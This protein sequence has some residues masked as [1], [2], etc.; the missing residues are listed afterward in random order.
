MGIFHFRNLNEL[1]WLPTFFIAFIMGNAALN[2]FIL[3]AIIYL[4]FNY[5]KITLP[6]N[7]SI[8][9]L[10]LFFCYVF[11]I[12]FFYDEV[13]LKNISQLRFFFL[14]YFF[15]FLRKN[16]QK[17]D[18]N[19]VLISNIFLILISIDIIIQEKFLIDLFGFKLANGIPTGPFENEVAG[20]FISKI[21]FCSGA[22]IFLKT[23]QLNKKR[24]LIILLSFIAITL[25]T[26]RMSF[27]HSSIVLLSLI[28]FE[29]FI[30]KN[31]KKTIMIFF[32]SILM[33]FYLFFFNESF[34][35]NFIGKT[36]NQIGLY[37]TSYRIID[38]TKVV[39]LVIIPDD[40]NR[41]FL[42]RE[43][44]KASFYSYKTWGFENNEVTN[45]HK[46][47]FNSA[48]QIFKQNPYFG[49]GVKSFFQKCNNNLKLNKNL[50]LYICSTHPHN[51]HIQILSETGLFAY[52]LFIIVISY[53]IYSSSKN[54]L[55]NKK[56][57][58]LGYLVG[59]IVL[60][61]P[62]PSGNFFGTWPGSFF[63]FIL[64]LNIYENNNLK[65][66]F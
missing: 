13:N 36:I 61:L 35:I 39:N 22:Y 25:S 58:Q 24:I 18:S 41:K 15:F 5:K 4:V 11:F 2:I 26:E 66:N 44:P 29:L 43:F 53:I 27:F 57:Y 7:I 33:F 23:D 9:L 32:V 6:I 51:I 47:L 12:G 46:K 31:I 62:L 63:W 28:L 10:L 56:I 40:A 30:K 65:K 52:I 1:I 64:S 49:S 45:P 16:S 21:F 20:S 54:F 3:L 60:L 19:L 59:F 38:N 8:Y 14:I 42:D 55:K 37:K 34:K 48:V 50:N 17:F